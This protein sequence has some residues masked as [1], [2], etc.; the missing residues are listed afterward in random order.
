[1]G[2]L[3]HQRGS[4][5][6]R[7]GVGGKRDKAF[8]GRNQT[9]P[10]QD[11]QQVEVPR[12]F[13]PCFLPLAPA[14]TGQTITETDVREVH[15]LWHPKASDCHFPQSLPK[16][17]HHRSCGEEN[18]VRS[19]PTSQKAQCAANSSRRSAYSLSAPPSKEQQQQQGQPNSSS[20]GSADSALKSVAS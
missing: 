19:L 15:C 20:P 12:F 5:L 13:R 7:A 18:Q 3:L 14:L 8:L 11:H 16:T 6:G 1:M 4:G 2:E 17:L 9:N 10:W